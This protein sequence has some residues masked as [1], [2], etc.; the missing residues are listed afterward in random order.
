MASNRMRG[1]R[2]PDDLVTQ[3]V[4][5]ARTVDPA[6]AG[7][8]LSRLL[9]VGLYLVAGHALPEAIEASQGN[10]RGPAPRAER[11]RDSAGCAA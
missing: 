2:L 5:E 8:D 7:F 4:T 11:D 6:L 10:K 9:R 3:L 1:V